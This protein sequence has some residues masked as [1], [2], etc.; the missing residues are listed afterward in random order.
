LRIRAISNGIG[1]RIGVLVALLLQ[2][3]LLAACSGRECLLTGY[4]H[5]LA[6]EI[7]DQ[8]LLTQG[9]SVRV[10]IGSKP[11]DG[12]VGR[13]PIGDL[14]VFTLARPVKAETGTK[15]SV[16][17]LE[18]SVTLGTTEVTP[19]VDEPNGRGCGKRFAVSLL[20]QAG[21]LVPAPDR[22]GGPSTT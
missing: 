6:I 10:S 8:V 12:W 5:S 3:V 15:W 7:P 18:G 9:L 20:F 21:A 19:T 1:V 11:I 17:L 16:A 4:E 14:L 13:P 2:L 22:T